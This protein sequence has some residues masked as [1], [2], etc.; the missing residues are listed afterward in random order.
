MRGLEVG[1]NREAGPGKKWKD[2]QRIDEV[3][4]RNDRCLL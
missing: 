1:R 3:G 2:W 4:E